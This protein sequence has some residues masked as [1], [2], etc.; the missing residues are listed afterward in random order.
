MDFICAPHRMKSS[1]LLKHDRTT[2]EKWFAIQSYSCTPQEISHQ[3]AYTIPKSSNFSCVLII[4]SFCRIPLIDTHAQTSRQR[5]PCTRPMIVGRFFFFF[6]VSFYTRFLHKYQQL[7]R[8][9][10]TSSTDKVFVLHTR[11]QD[12]Q[13]ISVERQQICLVL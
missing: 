4:V 3:H 9:R 10:E 11:A 1:T 2:Y 6:L 5:S 7:I 13:N 8:N 12:E